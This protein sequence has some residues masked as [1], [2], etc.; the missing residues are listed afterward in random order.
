MYHFSDFAIL[1]TLLF[2]VI[3]Y[4]YHV[5]FLARD[6]LIVCQSITIRPFFFFW[7]GGGGAQGGG[8]WL[9]DCST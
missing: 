2:C 4:Q 6:D 7:G 9:K 3:N 8:M 5:H 1:K